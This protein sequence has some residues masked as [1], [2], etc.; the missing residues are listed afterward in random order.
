MVIGE[1]MLCLRQLREDVLVVAE[2]NG[3]RL[4]RVLTPYAGS[5]DDA[6]SADERGT[7]RRSILPTRLKT[8]L[9]RIK[10]LGRKGR[11]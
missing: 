5:F 3:H 8:L 7:G 11:R 6:R 2:M 4:P 10:N 9:G 1:I